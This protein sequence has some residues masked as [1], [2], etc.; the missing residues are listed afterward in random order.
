MTTVGLG[1]DTH[2]GNPGIIYQIRQVRS[3]LVL[4]GDRERKR[5]FVNP[6]K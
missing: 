1:W 2:A 6:E 3:Q 4:S 5:H